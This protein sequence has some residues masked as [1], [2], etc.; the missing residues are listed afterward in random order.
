M[1]IFRSFLYLSWVLPCPG[2]DSWKMITYPKVVTS[3]SV[4]T[5]YCDVITFLPW[6]KLDYSDF[7]HVK[8]WIPVSCGD[9]CLISTW[10][11]IDIHGC[12]SLVKI[13]FAPIC[14]CKTNRRICRHNASGLHSR[15]VTDLLWWRHNTKSEKTV[16][17]D[18]GEISN[19]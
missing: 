19:R 16:L 7:L 17:S 4:L 15:D 5:I 1:L 13:A 6:S 8:P 9:T 10:L 14:A 11:E 12:Y 3:V 18:N 2:T